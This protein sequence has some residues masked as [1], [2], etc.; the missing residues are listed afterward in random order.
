MVALTH[1]PYGMFNHFLKRTANFLDPHLSVVHRWLGSLGSFPAC[2]RQANVTP[3]LQGPPSSSVADLI[4]IPISSVLSYVFE[5]LV[6]LVSDDLWN[7]VVCFQPHS[8]LTGKVCMGTCDAHLWVSRTLQW[9]LESGQKAKIVQIDF[10]AAF[11]SVNQ[12]GIIYKLC[13]VGIGGTKEEEVRGERTDETN[14]STL[15]W[16][17]SRVTISPK[18]HCEQTQM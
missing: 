9:A 13:S 5:R 10:S 18:I 6:S 17:T 15:V 2:S 16:V 4:P 1:S 7:A 14:A 12:L 8:L 3:I 11:D